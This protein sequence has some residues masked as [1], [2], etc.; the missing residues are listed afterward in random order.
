[1]VK[2]YIVY[3]WND[4]YNIY[5]TKERAD[6]ACKKMIERALKNDPDFENYN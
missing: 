2:F 6:L 3:N 5:S 1:M 4:C